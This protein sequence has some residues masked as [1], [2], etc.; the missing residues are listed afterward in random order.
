[1]TNLRT[2]LFA[3]LFLGVA[4]SPAQ[5]LEPYSEAQTQ[6]FMD[7][8]TGAKSTQPSICSCAVQ[9]LATTVPSAALATFLQSQQGGGGFSLSTASVTTAAVV[10]DA[11]VACA[12]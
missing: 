10:T 3:A 2:A 8:C 4:A 11:L 1:M 7:W 5:A 9:R 12:R 6:E